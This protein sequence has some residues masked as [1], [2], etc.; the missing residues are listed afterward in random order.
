MTQLRSSR[1]LPVLVAASGVIVLAVTLAFARLPA[2]K[3]AASCWPA[4]AVFLFEFARSQEDLGRIFGAEGGE[5]RALNVKAMDAA[6]V[7]DVSV[8]IPAYTFFA[9]V[10]ALLVAGSHRRARLSA[11]AMA[12]A[13]AVSDYV[14]TTTLL[15]MTKS[16]EAATPEQM[17]IASTAAW[18]KFGL[19]ALHAA[20]LSYVCLA[21]APRRW[22]LGVALAMPLLGFIA[23]TVRFELHGL[24]KLGFFAG[25]TSLLIVGLRQ[26]FWPTFSP[27]PDPAPRRRVPRSS[28]ASPSAAS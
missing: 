1:V 7:M 16:L 9:S 11:I 3:A 27:P 5:C 10:A 18:I 17:L 24:M 23:M 20:V 25:W 2:V 28:S 22:L 8:Y 13:A 19:L 21:R 6:N 14:E 12:L 26:S 15:T 4:D